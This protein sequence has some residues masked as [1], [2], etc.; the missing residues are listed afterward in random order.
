MVG[1]QMRD[2]IKQYWWAFLLGGGCVAIM[3]A[4]DPPEPAPPAAAAML[5]QS[6][7]AS[8][9]KMIEVQSGPKR[10]VRSWSGNRLNVEDA[11][12]LLL[13]AETKRALLAA[14]A[15]AHF[16]RPATDLADMEF[17]VAYGFRSGKRLAMLSRI[18]MSFD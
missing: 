10:I 5:D 6:A 12:W 3:M 1:D 4:L 13:P 8:C 15:C 11:R 14:A 17:T 16:G 2:T 18:G 7:R 9:A